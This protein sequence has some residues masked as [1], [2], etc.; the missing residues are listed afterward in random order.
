MNKKI[1]RQ[2]QEQV[3]FKDTAND[4]I[5]AFS[6]ALATELWVTKC[7][8]HS[9]EKLLLERQVFSKEEL[10][11]IPSNEERQQRQTELDEFTKNLM[12]TLEGQTASVSPDD[13]TLE[14]FE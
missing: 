13:E 1:D 6:M 4:R 14:R 12:K 5:L 9:L 10:E 7:R 11:A 2:Q 3:F 8:V